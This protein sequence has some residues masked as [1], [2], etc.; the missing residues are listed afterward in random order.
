MPLCMALYFISVF[1]DRLHINRRYTLWVLVRLN[2]HYVAEWSM[3]ST[4]WACGEPFDASYANSLD[5]IEL[6][7]HQVSAW[8]QN[9]Y[10]LFW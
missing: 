8:G 6:E 5:S 7:S 9:S 1:S 3:M 2:I 4:L 10:G